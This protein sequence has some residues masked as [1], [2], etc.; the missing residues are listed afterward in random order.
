MHTH[1]IICIFN[2]GKRG[3]EWR[4]EKNTKENGK[5][6]I[7]LGILKHLSFLSTGETINEEKRAQLQYK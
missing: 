4:E 3:K 7:P 6:A 2:G 1:T 5:Q